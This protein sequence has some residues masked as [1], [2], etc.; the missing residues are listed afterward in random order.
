MTRA[1]APRTCDGCADMI[2]DVDRS[3]TFELQKAGTKKGQFIKSKK[4]DFCHT[5]FKK[6]TD[7]GFLPDWTIMEKDSLTGK[8]GVV[9]NA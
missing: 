3:Y 5:C 1:K 7:N 9:D 8:W 4:G 2:D 6:L